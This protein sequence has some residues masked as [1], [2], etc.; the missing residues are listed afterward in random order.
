MAGPKSVTLYDPN[1]IE[2]KGLGSNFY[3]THND[4]GK[5]RDLTA[6]SELRQMNDGV[7][8][9]TAYAGSEGKAAEPLDEKRKEKLK[10][11]KELQLAQFPLKGKFFLKKY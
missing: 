10:G 2:I 3:A 1:P 7:Q 8:I 5:E 11:T 6:M 4:L 9:R